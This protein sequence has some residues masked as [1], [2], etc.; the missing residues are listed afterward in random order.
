MARNLAISDQSAFGSGFFLRNYVVERIEVG[1]RREK[2][3]Y[4]GELRV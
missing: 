2:I 3:A 1:C 4:L